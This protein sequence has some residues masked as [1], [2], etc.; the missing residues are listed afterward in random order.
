M[1]T[2]WFLHLLFSTFI[3][4]LSLLHFIIIDFLSFIT[5]NH[6]LF[7]I[8]P[9]E[10]ASHQNQAPCNFF[11]VCYQPILSVLSRAI[12][13]V[14]LLLSG[15]TKLN[16]GAPISQFARSTCILFFIYFICNS[17]YL[18]FHEWCGRSKPGGCQ[19]VGSGKRS[20]LTTQTSLLTACVLRSMVAVSN[21]I[22]H[23]IVPW[24]VVKDICVSR[25]V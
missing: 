17:F 21:Q 20:Q 12:I 25:P 3:F 4:I 24:R 6:K 15:D 8:S 1:F 16:L 18:R 7:F 11:L 10:P 19:M 23:M 22:S 9:H 2:S 13:F 5:S 14:L